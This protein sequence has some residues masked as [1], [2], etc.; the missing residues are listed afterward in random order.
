MIT[1]SF[2]L[3]GPEASLIW[4]WLVVVGPPEALEHY[5]FL[6]FLILSAQQLIELWGWAEILDRQLVARALLGLGW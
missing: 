1:F 4:S 5:N 2:S 6:S 3:T